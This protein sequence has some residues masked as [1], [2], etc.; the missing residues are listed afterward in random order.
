MRK[1]QIEPALTRSNTFVA[2]ANPSGAQCPITIYNPMH[3]F[4]QYMADA[5]A[6]AD[7]HHRDTGWERGR[8]LEYGGAKKYIGH[9]VSEMRLERETARHWRFT[10]NRKTVK[11]RKPSPP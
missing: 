7:T 10:P 3:K 9:R 6:R 4:F 11:A 1:P 5:V 8:P 2:N